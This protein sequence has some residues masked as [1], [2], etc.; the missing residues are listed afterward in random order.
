VLRLMLLLA[1]FAAPFWETSPPGDWSD[2]QLHRLL[3]SSP[4]SRSEKGARIYLASAEP[5]W[6]AERELWR[7]HPPDGG[8][9]DDGSVEEY[10]EFMEDNRHDYIVVAVYVPLPQYL[11]PEKETKRME[12]RSVLVVGKK[13]HKMVGHFPPTAA[14]HYLRLVFP[15]AVKA[16]DETFFFDLYVPGVPLPYRRLIFDVARMT[17]KGKPEW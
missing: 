1:F 14:D 11:E 2:E 15:P 4:W 12:N 10:V 5:L 16:A 9:Y 17:Y 8:E 3:G 7:R 13:K 6:L